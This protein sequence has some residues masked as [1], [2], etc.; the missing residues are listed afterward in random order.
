MM[1]GS[2]PARWYSGL[3]LFSLGYFVSEAVRVYFQRRSRPERLAATPFVCDEWALTCETARELDAA[4]G[5]PSPPAPDADAAAAPDAAAQLAKLAE[6]ALATVRE[7]AVAVAALTARGGDAASATQLTVLCERALGTV[8]LT[9][10]R[11]AAAEAPRT[12]RRIDP[13]ASSSSPPPPPPP[14][15]PR[16]SPTP[17]RIESTLDVLERLDSL[18]SS[19]LE[20][21]AKEEARPVSPCWSVEVSRLSEMDSSDS[22]DER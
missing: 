12:P 4:G 13:A 18:V 10:R 3:G 6:L 7:T 22:E 8:T 16:G 17:R 11:I 9:A 1:M 2:S 5:Y 14:S 15:P 19:D 21:A 20:V